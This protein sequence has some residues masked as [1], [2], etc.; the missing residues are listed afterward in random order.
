MQA[1]TREES[2]ITKTV[3]RIGFMCSVLLAAAPGPATT[4]VR[5][6]FA[7]LVQKAETIAVGTVSAMQADWDA[8]REIPHTRVTFTD[9]DIRKG[10]SHQTTLTLQF[11]G[12][13]IPDGA[14][15]Q[16]AG[17]PTFQLGDRLVVFVAGN[18]HYAVPLVG[19]WQGVYRV[20]VDQDSGTETVYTH[21]MQPV[22]AFPTASGGLQHDAPR[23]SSQAAQQS[24]VAV[25]TLGTFL[26]RIEAEMAHD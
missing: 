4:V 10:D 14:I 12:G 18:N 3:L 1:E 25:M 17:M 19:L 21:A 22:T 9:L 24:S 26:D 8:A 6:S 16:I 23:Q 7:D 15:L 11:L 20:V 13:P 2:R 5:Q